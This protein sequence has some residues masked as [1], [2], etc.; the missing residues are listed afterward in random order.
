M[1][2]IL[3]SCALSLL[4][5]LDPAAL[6]QRAYQLQQ[7]GDYA[8]AADA[9]REFLKARPDEVAGLA[10]LGVVLAKLGRYDEAIAEYE[11]AEKLLPNDPRIGLNL[12]LAYSKSGRLS[13]A[14]AKLEALPKDNQVTLLL[15]DTR[16]RMGENQ[17]VIELLKPLENGG[18]LAV[19]YML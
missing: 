7:A 11:A 9:Y 10:N 19:S 16:L 1:N 14:A 8:G 4:L 2:G 6:F 3:I 12:A 18:D 17:R 15:A 5:A 13:E